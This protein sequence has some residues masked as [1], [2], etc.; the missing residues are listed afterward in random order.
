MGVATDANQFH[1]AE[2]L[3]GEG[4]IKAATRIAKRMRKPGLGHANSVLRVASLLWR[5]G[6]KNDCARYLVRAS[7]KYPQNITIADEGAKRCIETKRY[8]EAL[9]LSERGISTEKESDERVA[10][11]GL[12]LVAL[13][14]SYEAWLRVAPRFE[15]SGSTS[16]PL[17]KVLVQAGEA[18]GRDIPP[19]TKTHESTYEAEAMQHARAVSMEEM[20]G[21]NARTTHDQSPHL[22]Y[23][24]GEEDSAVPEQSQPIFVDSTQGDDSKHITSPLTSTSGDWK[25]NVQKAN[26]EIMQD[27]PSIANEEFSEQAPV[28]GRAPKSETLTSPIPTRN[29]PVVGTIEDLEAFFTSHPS[30]PPIAWCGVLPPI[31]EGATHIPSR[32]ARERNEERWPRVNSALSEENDSA[33]FVLDA[34]AGGGWD[35]G[36][37]V[38]QD[39]LQGLSRP[40]VLI[41]NEIKGIPFA[42]WKPRSF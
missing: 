33:W 32:I 38:L 12:A 8:P 11:A 28:Q 20:A 22:S 29:R 4:D 31:I 39:S 5:C 9:K 2:Q 24:L 17:H 25:D 14:R 1:L 16:A 27:T 42:R 13:N 26:S 40:V 6:A 18:L 23:D 37:E 10:T 15:A 3:L 34:R 41:V 21:Y 19:L 30:P 36:D 35:V 7:E